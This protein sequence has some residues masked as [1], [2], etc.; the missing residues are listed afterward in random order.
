MKVDHFLNIALVCLLLSS[1]GGRAIA[2]RPVSPM[3]DQRVYQ[4]C[5]NGLHA[6]EVIAIIMAAPDVNF[7]LSPGSTDALLRGGVPDRVVKAIGSQDERHRRQCAAL[8]DRRGQSPSVAHRK[9]GPRFL[10]SPMRRAFTFAKARSGQ[11]YRLRSSTG[12][13]V[14][15]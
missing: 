3:D 2:Q 8:E 13:P 14:G 12:K 10:R 4:L 11:T 6:D 1:F 15:S 7:E 5:K 9:T